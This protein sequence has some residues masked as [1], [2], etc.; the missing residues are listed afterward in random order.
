MINL[1]QLRV[2]KAIFEEKSITSAARRLRISQPAVSKQLA[3]LE[4]SVGAALVDRLPRGIRLTA[5]GEVLEQHA[6]RIFLAEEAAEA[7]LATLLGLGYGRLAVGASTTVGSYLVPSV[8]GE[9]H[10]AHPNIGLELEIGNTSSIQ[11]A[12]LDS[13]VDIGLIE[14]MVSSESLEVDVFAQDEMVVIVSPR[15][16]WASRAEVEAAELATQP[17]LGRERGSGSRAVVEAALA[18]RGVEVQFSMSL[19]STEAVKN[20]VALGLGVAIVSRL[21]VALEIEVGQLRAVALAGRRIRRDLNRVRLRGKH[22][23]PAASEFL[24]LLAARYGS[25][26]S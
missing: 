6:R 9:L 23:S 19:G 24:R 17:F 13:R 18:E 11:Q 21:S 2:F 12:V 14:G 3:E 20:A 7:E 8:F 1:N 10:L 26:G 15:H 16:I 25:A 4:S 5:A 22:P